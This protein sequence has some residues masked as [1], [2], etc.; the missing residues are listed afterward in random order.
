MVYL[1]KISELACSADNGL[2]SN[3]LANFLGIDKDC[4]ALI[5]SHPLVYSNPR[6]FFVS[7]FFLNYRTVICPN[8]INNIAEKKPMQAAMANS[9]ESNVI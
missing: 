2:L 9:F 1:Y 8:K 5:M 3:F 6:R 4:A 7:G